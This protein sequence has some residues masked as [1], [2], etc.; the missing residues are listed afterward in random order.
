MFDPVELQN[1]VG[2][3]SY[4]YNERYNYIHSGENDA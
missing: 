4:A 2:I 1:I 3:C